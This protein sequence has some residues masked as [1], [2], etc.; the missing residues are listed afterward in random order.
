V[1]GAIPAAADNAALDAP[2]PDNRTFGT[3][4]AQK[5]IVFMHLLPSAM[6]LKLKLALLQ[7]CCNVVIRL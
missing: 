1:G 7:F 2:E 5:N 6:D 4:V 3:I